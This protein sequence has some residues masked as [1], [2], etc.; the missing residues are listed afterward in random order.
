MPREVSFGFIQL[1]AEQFPSYGLARDETTILST[2]LTVWVDGVLTAQY[3]LYDS[4][5][6]VVTFTDGDINQPV[7][8]DAVII[9]PRN[10]M[11]LPPVLGRDWEFQVESDY[12]V[13]SVTI[14]QSGEEMAGA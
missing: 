5:Y 4:R 9:P 3:R 11:R 10:I 7:F 14:G 1:E 2:R 6:R 12:E 8:S 13:F